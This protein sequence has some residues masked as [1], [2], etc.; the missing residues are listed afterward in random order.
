MGI[1]AKRL[2]AEV[3]QLVAKEMA[4]VWRRV[5]V[6]VVAK[7][8]KKIRLQSQWKAFLAIGGRA[9]TFHTGSC[10]KEA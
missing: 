3:Y 6:S 2:M 7:K 8:E 9:F 5:N 1:L 4:K 10:G